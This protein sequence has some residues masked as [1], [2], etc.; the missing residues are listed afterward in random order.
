[1]EVTARVQRRPAIVL[2]ALSVLFLA[3]FYLQRSRSPFLA[4][5]ARAGEAMAI[6]GTTGLET[7]AV[8]AIHE[9]AGGGLPR[10][11]LEQRATR[12]AD[13]RR[14]FADD[15][16]AILA[17]AGH[18]AVAQRLHIEAGDARVLESRIRALPEGIV[19]VRFREMRQ[20]FAARLR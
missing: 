19:A 2:A 10:T 6:A 3:A 15:G 13:L 4:V 8:M 16:L 1:M 5:E 14:R 20:R 12:F 11:E 7:A 17:L 18:E 9:L